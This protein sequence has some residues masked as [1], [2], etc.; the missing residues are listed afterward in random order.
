MIDITQ[1]PDE[2]EAQTTIPTRKLAEMGRTFPPEFVDTIAL[3][4]HTTAREYLEAHNAPIQLIELADYAF[5]LVRFAV[6]LKTGTL[7][8]LDADD[9]AEDIAESTRLIA[10]LG[11]SFYDPAG[12]TPSRPAIPWEPWI[13]K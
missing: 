6:E 12:E 10:E 3:N 11:G 4:A 2:R 13:A 7:H 8:D 9:V 1:D 5:E